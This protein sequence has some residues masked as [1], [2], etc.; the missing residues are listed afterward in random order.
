LES[1]ADQLSRDA[2]WLAYRYPAHKPRLP[3]KQPR[4]LRWVAVGA[5]VALALLSLDAW[6]MWT[7]PA[8]PQPAGPSEFAA[9][10][11]PANL[12][13]KRSGVAIP[14]RQLGASMP[15][16]S[17]K[18]L[19]GAEKEAVLDLLEERAPAITNASLSL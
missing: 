9:A 2:Q 5:V 16:V 15:P 3:L 19:N 14:K 11:P 6:R 17:Y 4:R 10:Q 13:G 12:N 1:L 18:D 8:R 7:R